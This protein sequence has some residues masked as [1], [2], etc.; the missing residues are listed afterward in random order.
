MAKQL[1]P[2]GYAVIPPVTDTANA[3]YERGFNCGMRLGATGAVH[4][5]RSLR[6]WIETSYLTNPARTME[7][8]VLRLMSAIEQ[9]I[10]TRDGLKAEA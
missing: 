7:R 9:S 3:D 8:E 10:A 2:V 6:E 1:T 4:M 5:A